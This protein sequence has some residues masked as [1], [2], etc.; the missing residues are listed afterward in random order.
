MSTTKAPLLQVT[1]LSKSFAQRS[2]LKD[3]GFDLWPGEV[4][5]IVGES[6]S[7]KSTLLNLLAGRME[8][9]AGSIHYRTTQGELLDVR[10]LSVV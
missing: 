7:G 8:P 6:G 5:A 3:V 10:A 4:L 9:D 1:G 2:A